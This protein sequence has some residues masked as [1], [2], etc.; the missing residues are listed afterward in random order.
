MLLFA[1]LRSTVAFFSLFFTLDMAF[2]LLGIGYLNPNAAGEPNTGCI[3]AGG[4]FGLLAAF[5]AWYN[6]LA[7]ILDDSNRFVQFRPTSGPFL[8]YA[9]LDFKEN[10]PNVFLFSSFFLIPVV[11]FPWSDTGKQRKKEAKNT[12]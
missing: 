3:K 7:G 10:V 11:H 12:V 6:A 2:L 9:T 5:L 1:T 8:S 4:V